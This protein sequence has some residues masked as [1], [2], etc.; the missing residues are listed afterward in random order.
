M[1]G[2]VQVYFET[3]DVEP[4]SENPTEAP[5]IDEAAFSRNAARFFEGD[6]VIWLVDSKGG[7]DQDPVCTFATSELAEIANDLTK[8]LWEFKNGA[9]ADAIWEFRFGYQSHWGDHLHRVRHYLHG[10]AAW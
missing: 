9:E 3:P 2:L 6:D 10:L 1:D 5:G 4:L 7:H 8:V